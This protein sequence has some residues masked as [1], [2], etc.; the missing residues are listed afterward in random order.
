MKGKV[1]V[2]VFLA[3][4][5]LIFLFFAVP[6]TSDKT[7][8]PSETNDFY[9]ELM[10]SLLTT[11]RLSEGPARILNQTTRMMIR[12]LIK[13]HPGMHF[14]AICNYLNLPLGVVEYHL[15][16]LTK[17]GLVSA[18]RDGRYKRY[19]EFERFDR[20]KMILIS[21]LRR[22]TAGKILLILLR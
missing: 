2:A 8:R 3:A 6:L 7:R 5:I 20:R 21:L 18:F 4:S 9:N 14:K 12:N 1:A 17:A 10:T 13:S 22:E 16:V 19:F 15:G 11:L